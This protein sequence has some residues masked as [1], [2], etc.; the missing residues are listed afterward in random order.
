MSSSS[1]SGKVFSTQ[2]ISLKN[3]QMPWT[4][5][6]MLPNGDYDYQ[7]VYSSIDKHVALETIRQHYKRLIGIFPGKHPVY[8]YY[9]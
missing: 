4:V 2:K 9:D 5:I 1:E 6:H 3:G 7:V 8:F